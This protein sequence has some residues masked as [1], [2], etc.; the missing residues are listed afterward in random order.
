MYTQGHYNNVYSGFIRYT[1]IIDKHQQYIPRVI[2]T[3]CIQGT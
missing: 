2:I 1:S 3:M